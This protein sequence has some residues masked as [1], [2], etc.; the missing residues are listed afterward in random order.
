MV[1]LKGELINKMKTILFIL[2]IFSSAYAMMYISEFINKRI[3]RYLKTR[4]NDNKKRYT[5]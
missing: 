3:N 4:N 5:K 2:F 1:C